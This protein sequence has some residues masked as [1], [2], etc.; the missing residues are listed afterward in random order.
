M[1]QKV[2]AIWARLSS[3]TM[4]I[5]PNNN[6]AQRPPIHIIRNSTK[7]HHKE[8]LTARFSEEEIKAAVWA[9]GGDKSPGP[10]GFNFNFIKQFWETLKPDFTR[11]LD[12]F[13]INGRFPKGS[14]ASFIALISKTTNP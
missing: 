11:F 5:K 9:C 4:Q 6:P 1:S 12:E 14:N 13:Y 10:D 7:G 3:Q 8:C 2:E